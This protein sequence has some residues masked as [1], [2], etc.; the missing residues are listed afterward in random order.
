MACNSGTPAKTS[1]SDPK[2]TPPKEVVISKIEYVNDP[3]EKPKSVN[4]KIDTVSVSN[5]EDLVKNAK[6]NTVM[7]LEKGTYNLESD[8]VYYMTKE[9]RKIIDKKVVETQ[10][11]GGQMYFSG[12][13]NFQL[14]G[15][16]GVAIVSKNPAAVAFFV[17]QGRNL[18]FSNL[19]IRKDVEGVAELS[20]ISKCQDVELDRCNFNGGGTYGIY[21]NYV[22]NI[23]IKNSKISNCT[24]GGVKINESKG[25]EFV[26]S[27]L[28]DNVCMV[29]IF[30]F[31]GVGSQ[32]VL[33][34]VKIVNNKRNPSTTFMGSERLLGVGTNSLKLEN[35]VI[36][37]NEGYKYLGINSG[38]IVKSQIEGL[39]ME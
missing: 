39:S 38:N 34:N 11:I 24:N 17:I 1:E 26:N 2:T 3:V 5:V 7:Y 30:H 6:S 29:P 10:S 4:S 27:T 23:K 18:K 12:L 32:V 8:L 22:T 16:N 20:Y 37:S 15:K 33:N 25:V 28:I 13:E 14:I 19:T 35:C 21:I 31:Y 9:E 36:H